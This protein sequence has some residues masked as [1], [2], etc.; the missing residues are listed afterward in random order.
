VIHA[1]RAGAEEERIGVLRSSAVLACAVA[2]LSVAVPAGAA[3]DPYAALLAPSGTCGAAADALGLDAATAQAAMLCLTNYARAQSGL[4]P[5]RLSTTLDAAGQAKLAADLSCG[6]FSHT[7]CSQ[8][9]DA[10]FAAYVQGA[11][12]Y[13]IGE[14]IAWG[15]GSFGTPRN[16]MNGWLHSAGHREN[17]LTAAYA[18]LGIGYLSGQSFQGYSGATLWSQEF[19]VR[20]PTGAQ[21]S[22]TTTKPTQKPFAKPKSRKHR[23]TRRHA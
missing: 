12:S 15:T 9:F 23:K 4:A 8:P 22:A 2:A 5:L 6:E 10:V 21:S 20:S 19:G 16:T 11:T 17:I 13:E 18:E 7:P 3:D 14:N 1:A